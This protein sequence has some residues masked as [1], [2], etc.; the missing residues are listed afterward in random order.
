MVVY[1][2]VCVCVCAHACVCSVVQ[3]CLTLCNPMDCSLPGSSVHGIFQARILERVAISSSRGSSWPRDQTCIS[4]ICIGRRIFYHSTTWGSS[5]CM[6]VL[7]SQFVPPPC[8][9][10]PWAHIHSLHLC[11]HSFPASRFIWTIFSRFHIDVLLYNT[12]FLFLTYF[13]LCDCRSI[14]ISTK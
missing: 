1:I 9:L 12:C 2:Y 14:Y 5:V 6:S 13:T 4:C 3:L 10:L 11:L 7:I 8:S